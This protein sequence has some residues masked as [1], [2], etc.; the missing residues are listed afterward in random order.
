MSVVKLLVG[1]HQLRR[2]FGDVRMKK[3]SK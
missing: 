1:P 3:R 2:Q